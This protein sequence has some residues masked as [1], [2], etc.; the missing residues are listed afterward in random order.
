MFPAILEVA[1]SI[2]VVY[3]L[4]S[5]LVSFIKEMI[6][7][8][9][10]K[11]GRMLY[12]SLKN[13]FAE[14]EEATDTLV[15]KVYESSFVN[16]LAS[17]FGITKYLNKRPSYIHNANFTEALLDEIR[18]HGTAV[19]FKS[20][21]DIKNKINT[22]PDSF[23]KAKLIS[24]MHELEDAG[25]G[26]IA[27]VK[28]KISEW[29]DSYMLTVTE[30]YKNYVTV[31][32]FFISLLV[33]FCMNLDTIVLAKYF[34]ENKEQRELV[35]RYAE[36]LKPEDLEIDPNVTGAEREKQVKA[37]TD[38]VKKALYSFNLPLGWENFEVKSIFDPKKFIG[39]F[40]TTI[41]LTLGAPFWYQ[42]M[43][44]LLNIRKNVTA[45]K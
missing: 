42:I 19:D 23:I 10:N 30:V 41:S 13:L 16:N 14:S 5:T 1:I 20:F 6:A 24:I 43:V 12:K 9:L 39:L 18:K 31:W 4:M 25:K 7:M 36:N 34:Y 2:I 35:L 8:V 17:K 33:S 11:R 26:T 32:V 21:A 28:H 40:L 3:F 44:N 27:N 45:K 37:K 22:M 29:F 15:D 38:Q